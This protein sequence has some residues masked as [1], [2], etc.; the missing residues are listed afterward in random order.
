M[1]VDDAYKV[2]P[3]ALNSIPWLRLVLLRRDV[4]EVTVLQES[5]ERVSAVIPVPDSMIS[6]RPRE[7][8]VMSRGKERLVDITSHA[9]PAIATGEVFAW[10]DEEHVDCAA[11]TL[12]MSDT[13]SK[14]FMTMMETGIVG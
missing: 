1:S 8:K 12:A 2:L 3:S 7:S 6:S 9:N 11:T 5:L 4:E 13:R 14:S 10:T